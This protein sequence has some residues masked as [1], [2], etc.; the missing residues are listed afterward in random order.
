MI[1]GDSIEKYIVQ[2][3]NCGSPF[4]ATDA[5]WCTCITASR[6]FVCPSCLTCFCQ[7]PPSFK[8][9]FW[10]RA[11]QSLWQSK[12][13]ERDIAPP[14][15]PLP[16]PSAVTRPLVIVADDEPAVQRIVTLAVASLG[17]GCILARDGQ[18]ALGLTLQY[19]PDLLLTDAL[20]PKLDGREVCRRLKADPSTKGTKIVIMTSAYTAVKY[21]VEA[22][23]AFGV[24]EY[25]NKPLDFKTLRAVLQRMIG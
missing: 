8:Q 20:M 9:E 2:C 19:H 4:D 1:P 13:A 24:D 23:K 10:S 11:P 18:E 12:L 21:K 22:V 17:Y 14:R 25:L 7:A 15:E 3:I 16:T 5:S 6:S